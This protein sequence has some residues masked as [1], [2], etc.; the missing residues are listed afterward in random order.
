MFILTTE[1]GTDLNKNSR[2]A[3]FCYMRVILGYVLL[4]EPVSTMK[5]VRAIFW[6]KNNWNKANLN[7]ENNSDFPVCCFQ[8]NIKAI[9]WFHKCTAAADGCYAVPPPC[10]ATCM[11]T[12]SGNITQWQQGRRMSVTLTSGLL[13]MRYTHG[14]LCPS[15]DNKEIYVDMA[16]PSLAT[17]PPPVVNWTSVNSGGIGI[18][19]N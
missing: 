10:V 11:C 6:K 1:T 7:H 12:V 14:G 9:P 13:I 8:N 18:F 3:F 5:P 4:W 16:P 17:P 15:Q 19:R 2:H